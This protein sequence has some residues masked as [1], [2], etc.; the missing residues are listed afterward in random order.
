MKSHFSVDKRIFACILVVSRK[1]KGREDYLTGQVLFHPIGVNMIIRAKQTNLGLFPFF[2]LFFTGLLLM[3]CQA[4]VTTA[5]TSITTATALAI[6]PISATK[7]LSKPP[8][9]STPA[10]PITS[11][12]AQVTK[13]RSSK[14][15]P[16]YKLTKTYTLF[17]KIINGI[18]YVRVDYPASYFSDGIAVSSVVTGTEQR[19]FKT[20]T[21][22]IL[23]RT[24][25][26]TVQTA[27]SNITSLYQRL[28]LDSIQKYMKGNGFSLAT[29]SNSVL[30]AGFP[31]TSLITQ[32]SPGRSVLS[33]KEYFDLTTLVKT[34]SFESFITPDGCTHIKTE[35][36]A[37]Q[38]FLGQPV[39][40]LITNVE[41]IHNPQRVDV[42][43]RKL[44][45]IDDLSQVPTMSAAELTQL[46]TDPKVKILK[47]K[48]II[49]DPASLDDTIT[50][51]ESYANVV[52]NTVADSIFN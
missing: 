8:S 42:S 36:I 47:F 51:T 6:D 28:P 40:T 22:E 9:V 29:D 25:R 44:P 27:N 35:A 48:P 24:P 21:G 43:D 20:N 4:P 18:V 39:P 13:T 33:H 1:H 3:S 26:A 5:K 10:T 14:R 50:T 12:T 46:K 19:I 23:S 17:E 37:Y 31:N 38:A 52:T 34:G 30:T 49:G 11:M 15:D 16:T 45:R 41:D 32:S 7:S 2:F